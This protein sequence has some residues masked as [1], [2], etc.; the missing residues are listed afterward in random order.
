MRD[1]KAAMHGHARERSGARPAGSPRGGR[2]A[3]LSG[4]RKGLSIRA[5]MSTTT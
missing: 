4:R 1:V 3:R 5:R 2:S